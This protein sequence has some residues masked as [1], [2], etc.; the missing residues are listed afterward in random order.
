MKPIRVG[1]LRLVDSAPVI[2]ARDQGI[3]NSLGLAVEISVEPSWANIAD[4]LAYGLLDAAIMLPPL[5][6][7]AAAGLRGPRAR[8]VVPLSLSQGGNAIVLGPAAEAALASSTYP[9]R[10]RLREWLRGFATPPRFA[11]VHAFSTHNL[12]LRYWLAAGGADPD[13]DIETV[14]IPPADVVDALASGAIIG[15]CA[16]APWGDVAERRGVGRVLIGTSVIWPFHP[17]KCL[18]VSESWAEAHP[19]ALHGLLRAVLRAQLYCDS[20]ANAPAIAR[21]LADPAGL[22]LPEEPSLAALPGGGGAEQIR[23]HTREAWFPA[24]AHAMWFLGQMDR[25]GWLQAGED[26]D[27]LASSVYRSDLAAA[28]V[29]SEGLYEA[30]LLPA[31]EGAAMLPLIDDEA[32]SADWGRKRR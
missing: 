21:M 17:E 31:L 9:P 1:L 32:F 22:D 16:G 28:A 23:F 27:T 18:C 19:D 2:V 26:L 29:E 7:A 3:F 14:V 6:L 13:R 30:A 4:K 20:P 12:L 10:L 8:V 24:K 15:F 25:W 5:A 11:V